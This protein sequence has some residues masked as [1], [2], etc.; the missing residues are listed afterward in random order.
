MGIPEMTFEKALS[1]MHQQLLERKAKESGL[2]VEQV[3]LFSPTIKFSPCADQF[4]L[5]L[6][7]S[8]LNKPENF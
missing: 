5:K 4:E 6:D 7:R 3:L 8:D 1:Q 2:P